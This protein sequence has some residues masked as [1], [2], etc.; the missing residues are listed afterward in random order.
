M[1]DFGPVG[2]K[3]ALSVH[4]LFVALWL[5]A[6]V[7]MMTIAFF[8]PV[9]QTGEELYGYRNS[10][11]WI[12]DWVL[13]IAAG[14]TLLSGM[15][16]A[17]RTKWGFF[18][19]YWVSLKLLT[20]VL[21]VAFGAVCLGPWITTT[22]HAVR[23]Q[24]IATLQGSEYQSANRRALFWGTVQILVLMGIVIVSVHKPWGK[25]PWKKP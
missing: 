16:L 4:L 23:D 13:V 1:S 7:A 12:D 3:W 21:M 18:K 2:R 20:T 19:W 15:L 5:G 6:A 10:L 22:A 25:I 9:P 8:H 17:W 14:G 11:T 24:G